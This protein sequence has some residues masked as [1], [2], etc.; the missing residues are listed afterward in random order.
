M[1]S[2]STYNLPSK[3]DF[4]KGGLFY[5]LKLDKKTKI[6]PTELMKY[7]FSD[8]IDILFKQKPKPS[9]KTMEMIIEYCISTKKTALKEENELRKKI[10]KDFET[11]Q[12][13]EKIREYFD[14]YYKNLYRN[15]TCVKVNNINKH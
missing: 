6:L 2:P 5:N 10:Q 7:I 8:Y 3:N 15:C 11:K 14:S 13:E 9:K 1:D 12:L 4:K